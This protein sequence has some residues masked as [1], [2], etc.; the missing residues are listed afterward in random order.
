MAPALLV[1]VVCVYRSAGRG[2]VALNGVC[3]L[4]ARLVMFAR[5]ACEPH[6]VFFA[7]STVSAHSMQ[8]RVY[9]AGKDSQRVGVMF[10]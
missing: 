9:S 8:I 10:K 2:A 3:A 1:S 4:V 6:R 7:H 5:F